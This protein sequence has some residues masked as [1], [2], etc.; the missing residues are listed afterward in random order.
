MNLPKL[1]IGQRVENSNDVPG[2][3]WEIKE[4]TGGTGF[5]R[6]TLILFDNGT[7]QFVTVYGTLSLREGASQI[8]KPLV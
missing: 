6:G 5:E 2:I 4:P 7:F 3:V 8:V 1:Q